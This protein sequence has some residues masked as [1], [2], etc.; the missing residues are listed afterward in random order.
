[1]RRWPRRSAAR[2]GPGT[3]AGGAREILLA[4]VDS[5]RRDVDTGEDL[6][7]ALAL[8]VGP[9][10]AAAAAGLLIGRVNRR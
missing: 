10:T 4:G 7:A 9:H 5:V 3:A 8:G 2:P 1:M 6:R